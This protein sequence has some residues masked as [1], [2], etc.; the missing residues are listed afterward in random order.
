MINK[1]FFV[2]YFHDAFIKM[3]LDS[4]R[5]VADPSQSNLA[6]ITV[7][8]PYQRFE[9][10]RLQEDTVQIRGKEI[11]VNGAGCFFSETQN[12]VFFKCLYNKE[13]YHIWNSKEYKTYKEFHP[14]ITIYDGDD[15]HFS[16]RLYEAINKYNIKFSFKVDELEIYSSKY[17]NNLFSLK[18][19]VDYLFLSKLSGMLITKDNIE[20]YT[21]EQRITIIEKL[22]D[23]F[24]SS[25]SCI[26]AID[27]EQHVLIDA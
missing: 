25:I 2:I 26:N 13:L 18:D 11:G 5:L 1:F 9:K 24:S 22:C 21:N 7:K 20:N 6:H 17:K 19:E 27:A 10:K 23:H 3:M 16:R 4:L 14:H 15:V 8:G 12:T